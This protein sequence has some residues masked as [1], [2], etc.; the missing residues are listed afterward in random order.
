LI[1]QKEKL[2]REQMEKEIILKELDIHLQSFE[3]TG[4]IMTYQKE[5]EIVIK[6]SPEIKAKVSRQIM[7]VDDFGKY[8]GNIFENIAKEKLTPGGMVGKIYHDEEFNHESSD[9][10]LFVGIREA[11]GADKIFQAKMCASTVHKG[12]YSTLQEAYGALVKL[13]DESN[14]EIN[15]APFEIYLKSH[16]DGL[17]PEDWE[18]EVYFPIKE[19]R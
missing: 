16:V 12:A 17:A 19:K 10:E 11:E 7:S 14:Y 3:R 6:N 5:Y 13:I 4:D 15:G 8:Y 18:T 1:E 9:M 2:Q